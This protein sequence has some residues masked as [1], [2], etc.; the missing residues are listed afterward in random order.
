MKNINHFKLFFLAVAIVLI[1]SSCKKDN[2][3]TNPATNDIT[4]EL[5][6]YVDG[7]YDNYIAD[8]PEYPGGYAIHVITADGEGFA[9]KGIDPE[10]TD[11]YHFRAQSTTKTFTAAGIMILHQRGLLSVKDLIVDTIPEKN[12]PYIPATH[13]FNIPYKN[14]IT[15]WELLCHRAGVYDIV[16]YPVNGEMYVEKVLEGDPNYTFTYADIFSVITDNQLSLFEPGEMWG[17]SNEGYVLLAMIIERVSGKTYKQFMM[18]EIVTPLGL[19]NTSFVCEGTEQTL[20]EPYVESWFYTQEIQFTGTEENMSANI[21][22][23][24]M[25]TSTKDLSKFYKLLLKGEAGVSLVN[26]NKFMKDCRPIAEL[27]TVGYGAALFRYEGLGYGHGGD[28][29]GIS[30]RCYTDPE[31]DFTVLVLSNCWNYFEGPGNQ[32]FFMHQTLML[33]EMMYTIKTGFTE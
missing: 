2:K 30:V 19:F 33:E 7:I 17:Y 26:V 16:N 20:P 14:Q 12:I 31:K 25:I 18:D 8:F 9:Q 5:E 13:S 28:G 22:E 27:S 29:S 11:E 24:N 10:F 15:I 32:S 1:I 6:V 21:G 4:P 3:E 23:G